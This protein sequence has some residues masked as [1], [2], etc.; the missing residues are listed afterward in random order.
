MEIIYRAKDGKEFT[1]KEDCLTY[2]NGIDGVRMW[3]RNGR[4]NE[5][6]KAFIL[7]LKDEQANLAFFEMARNQGDDDISGIVEGEDYGLFMWNEWEGTYCYIAN[8]DLITLT[9]AA[10]NLRMEGLL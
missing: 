10:N 7:Y 5:T 8:D 3:C 4:T 6:G 2:E 9:A 1:N